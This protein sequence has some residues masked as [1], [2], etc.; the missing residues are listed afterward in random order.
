MENNKTP[1]LA[2]KIPSLLANVKKRT[3]A[4]TDLAIEN[5][6]DTL[7]SL[8]EQ[9]F[10]SETDNDWQRSSVEYLS[11]FP[12]ENHKKLFKK[13]LQTK[14]IDF[15]IKRCAALGLGTLKD[16]S[17]VDLIISAC[18]EES[19]GGDYNAGPFITAL[20]MIKTKKAKKE[21]EKYINSE[22]ESIKELSTSVLSNW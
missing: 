19:E 17:S 21:I 4:L 9:I 6:L 20:G 15:F 13:I 8:Y 1:Q 11:I 18:R 2:T 12:K 22:E 7:Q 14:D 3:V 16:E 10:M 5:N